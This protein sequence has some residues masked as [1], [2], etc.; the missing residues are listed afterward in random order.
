[1]A[2]DTT[3]LMREVDNVI[4]SGEGIAHYHLTVRLRAG[5]RWIDPEHLDLFSLERN[6]EQGF[7]D[8][9]IIQLLLAR[10]TYTHQILTHRDD[11]IADVTSIPL[12]EG[13]G[14]QRSNQPARVRRYR[15]IVMDKQ[16]AALT[17]R[18]PFADDEE[19]L[20]RSGMVAV[21]FQLLNEALYQ[22][23]M[24][25]VGRNY[26]KTVPMQ[27]LRSLLTET[28]SITDSRNQ[29]QIFGVNVAEGYNTTVRNHVMIPDGTPLVD[30]PTLLQQDEGGLYATDVGCYLQRGYWY[31]YPLY[32]TERFPKATK[33]LTVLHVPSNRYYNAE[34]T[35]RRTDR[36]VVVI[37]SGTES[38]TND[39]GLYNQLNDGNAARFTDARRLMGQFDNVDGNRTI[40]NRRDNLFEFQGPALKTAQSNARWAKQRA[41]DNPMKHYS[42]MAKRNGRYLTVQWMHGDADLL[43]PGMPV[44]YMTADK[45]RLKVLYGTLMGVHEQRVA[46]TGGVVAE[47]YPSSITL[48]LFITREGHANPLR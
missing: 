13:T 46:K 28:T 32:N 30:T 8:E 36:Q 23:R 33:T 24:I 21:Q 25:T 47:E 35:Y 37:A 5:T 11:L 45:G 29:Q 16:D 27:A 14:L 48:N 34:R 3:L 38:V 9:L 18:E 41:T 31:L 19:D 44:K 40:M 42:A 2:V 17:S 6:Y 1:M 10:G 43:T 22:T 4:Q 15:A 26:R 7:G 12:K 20:N 39:E